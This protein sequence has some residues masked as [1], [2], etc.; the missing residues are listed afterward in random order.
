MRLATA[1]LNGGTTAV[2][3][4]GHAAV[5][6]GFADVRGFLA[7]GEDWRARADSSVG[8]VHELASLNLAPVVPSPEKILCIGLNYRKHAIEAGLDLPKHPQLFSKWWRALIGPNDPLV[9]PGE[10]E[11]I[12]WEA[13]LGVVIGRP[14]RRVPVEQALEYVAGYTILNDVSMRD[15]QRRT[16]QFT[17]GKTFEATTPIGPWLVT[18]EEV[19]DGGDL[20]ISCLVNGELMQDARTSDLIFSVAELVSYLSQI[21]T[22]VPGDVIATGT[23]SGVGAT[24]KPPRFLS[25]GETLTTRIEGIGELVNVCA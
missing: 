19:G 13:E 20:A 23:A 24:R 25:A 11:L 14:A 9:L 3:I 5:E 16:S 10:S 7:E 22:L 4:D 1:R 2:R 8:K 18:G 21:I 15:W 6:L 12:D 17:Q